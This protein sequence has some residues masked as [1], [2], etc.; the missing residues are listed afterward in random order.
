MKKRFAIVFLLLCTLLYAQDEPA[1]IQPDFKA[2]EQQIK[3][4]NSPLYFPKLFDRFQK[5]DSTLTLQER[6]HLYYGYSFTDGYQP[7]FS[8]DN[9]AEIRRLINTDNLSKEQMERVIALSEDVLKGYPFNISIMGY[10]A[11]F[12]RA[13]GKEK[14]AVNEEIRANLIVDTILS[15]GDGA[16]KETCFFVISVGNEYELI[17][18]LGL[19]YDG[20]QK[21]VDGRYDYLTIQENDYGLW[22]LY[23]DV[24]RVMATLK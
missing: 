8:S 18:T 22:G 12:F 15:T 19:V 21:L 17:N 14:L 20:Q 24:S 16:N 2:I 6:Y 3:D 23:F 13:L 11:Y 5:A 1:Y 7:Y 4:K 10:R 9:A